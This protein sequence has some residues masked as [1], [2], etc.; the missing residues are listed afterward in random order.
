MRIMV[1]LI[2]M[3]VVHEVVEACEDEHG[4]MH[5][6]KCVALNWNHCYLTSCSRPVSL[7]DTQSLLP[8]A[9]SPVWLGIKSLQYRR[10][11]GII[12]PPWGRVARK[13]RG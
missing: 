8:L 1:T 12:Y 7:T 10:I 13:R 6:H 11:P 4:V 9:G 2:G 3:P 5:A